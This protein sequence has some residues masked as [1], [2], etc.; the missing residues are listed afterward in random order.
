MSGPYDSADTETARRP[1]ESKPWMSKTTTPPAIAIAPLLIIWFGTG[2]IRK[3]L[4]CALMVFFPVL[5]NTIV[6]IRSMD[7]C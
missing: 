4:I 3:I 1:F 6:G 2:K 5:V 7:N